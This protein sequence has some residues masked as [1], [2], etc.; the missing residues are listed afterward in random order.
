[1]AVGSN[2]TRGAIFRLVFFRNSTEIA[3][4]QKSAGDAAGPFLF[5]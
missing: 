1:M 2:P 5:R 4:E 3:A